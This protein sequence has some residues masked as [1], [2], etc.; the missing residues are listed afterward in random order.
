M[1]RYDKHIQIALSSFLAAIMLGLM[2][3][4]T[5]VE[6]LNFVYKYV[7]HTHSHIAMSGWVYLALITIITK[8]YLNNSIPKKTYRFIFGNTLVSIV[9]MLASFPFQGYALISI[10][11]ST[12]YLIASYFYAWAFFKYTPKEIKSTN[13]YK[14]IKY[15]V[16]YLIISS[17]GPWGIGA[18]MGTLG[19][20]SPL[21][22]ST[23]YLYLH[24][25]YNAWMLLGV[26]G[27]V[28][29]L[30]EDNHIEIDKNLFRKFLISFNIGV[31][32]TYLL[33]ILF[34]EPPSIIYILA[35][36]GAAIQIGSFVYL[37][38]T[39]RDGI[40]KAYQFIDKRIIIVL[41]WGFVLA[42]IKL[43]MQLI[44][45]FPDIA[46]LIVKNKFLTI[47][48]IHWV[49][50]GVIT[51]PLLVLLKHFKFIYLSKKYLIAYVLGFSLT[52]ILIFYK[53]ASVIF[54][55]YVI[56]F[57]IFNVSLF[58][59]SLLLV[60]SITVILFS[61]FFKKDYSSRLD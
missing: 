50:L 27:I 35:I 29:K 44:G 14:L 21:Y 19:S 30:L 6:N 42:S 18:V 1:I 61:Q 37:Y 9:G 11:F 39:L 32:I 23:I 15:A 17:I 33:S 60:G 46:A 22:H 26:I 52:E 57:Q 58:L 2:L 36:V 13:S 8:L 10:I 51:M 28:V 55:L 25:Q 34:V 48:F 47:G 40:K 45:A 5:A 12:L 54:G 7:V 24:Y 16:I 53:P 43:F 20:S 56:P 38:H 59:A 49:F 3:R 31:N 4:Y 41:K